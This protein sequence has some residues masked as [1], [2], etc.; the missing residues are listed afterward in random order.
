MSL[1]HYDV[2]STLFAT[3]FHQS[4]ERTEQA[5]QDGQKKSRRNFHFDL[6]D[7]GLVWNETCTENQCYL[8][9][10]LNTNLKLKTYGENWV[11]QAC[12]SR[13][14]LYG[15]IWIL[16]NASDRMNAQSNCCSAFIPKMGSHETLPK[17]DNKEVQA[18][19]FL[20][21]TVS[22]ASTTLSFVAAYCKSQ[23]DNSI[24]SIDSDLQLCFA[25]HISLLH[26]SFHR[27]FK[28]Q[29]TRCFVSTRRNLLLIVA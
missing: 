18:I 8:V 11:D 6:V 14:F 26:F 22:I 3:S 16:W 5:H 1:F 23:E 28:Q 10:K 12:L 20:I 29:S 15:S 27:L 4:S 25:F 7:S 21:A 17:F 2:G 19:V 13:V 24:L 9:W